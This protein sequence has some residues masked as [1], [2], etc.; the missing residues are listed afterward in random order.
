MPV[1]P[2]T[3]S[4]GGVARPDLDRA[5]GAARA[6][7]AA[8]P[9]GL[10]VSSRRDGPPA[11]GGGGAGDAG[12]LSVQ[13]LLEQGGVVVG[14][15][16]EPPGVHEVESGVVVVRDR[17]G[18]VGRFGR[19]VEEGDEGGRVRG[20]RGGD[21]QDLPRPDRE[22]EAVEGAVADA[23]HD[24]VEGVRHRPRAGLGHGS[25]LARGNVDVAACDRGRRVERLADAVGGGPGLRQH[26]A[27]E[28]QPPEGA[29]QEL[30]EA[31]RRD[32]FADRDRAVEGLVPAD[33][34]DDHQE[35]AGDGEHQARVG[36]AQAGGLERGP[37]RGAAGPPVGGGGRGRRS[38]ALEH[39]QAAQ[40]VA[41][42]AGRGADGLLV[43]LG[44][45]DQRS[46]QGLHGEHHDGHADHDDEPDL[47]RGE[48]QHPG[49]DQYAGHGAGAEH[50]RPDAFADAG[51]LDGRQADDLAGQRVLDPAARGEHP[52]GDAQAGPVAGARDD[53]LLDVEPDAAGRRQAGEQHG[54]RGDPAG[55]R[56]GV[57]GGD[58][59]VDDHTDDHGNGGLEGLM[60]RDQGRPQGERAPLGFGGL[61]EHRLLDKAAWHRTIR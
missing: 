45:V 42:D 24:E 53:A 57:A 2:G 27:G 10:A 6:S 51:G 29:E 58:G 35:G 32:Q 59:A 7:V 48:Q 40:Q 33:P 54:E 11:G 1:R 60:G 16:D 61:P 13:V 38:Q 43:G 22:I 41:G 46:G 37:Q 56:P 44:P 39:A 49:A 20:R 17:D 5:V 18:A 19:A 21:A 52:V 3:V 36:G 31:D 8:G 14:D 15:G 30:G 23:P 12:D 26:L 55:D 50:D 9:A 47:D 4:V 34:G 25:R 28:R